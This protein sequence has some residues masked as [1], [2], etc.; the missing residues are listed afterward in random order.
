LGTILIKNIAKYVFYFV[1]KRFIVF[2][3][4]YT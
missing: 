2:P 1:L 4:P 3:K